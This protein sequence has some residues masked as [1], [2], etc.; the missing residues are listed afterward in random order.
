MGTHPHSKRLGSDT[1]STEP[2]PVSR[3]EW[4]KPYTTSQENIGSII[5]PVVSGCVLLWDRE[6]LSHCSG[7]SS[8]CSAG[9][10]LSEMNPCLLSVL[11]KLFPISNSSNK[12]VS[13]ASAGPVPLTSF[14]PSIRF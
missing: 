13:D 12:N 9:L 7:L 8:I 4:R 5:T 3:L 1:T 6:L 10:M 11:L 2:G 14:V